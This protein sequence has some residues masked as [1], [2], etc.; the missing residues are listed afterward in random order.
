MKA[1]PLKTLCQSI[2][3]ASLILVMNYGE[4][5]GGGADIRMHVPFALRG[6]ILAQLADIFILG[7]VIFA[8]LSLLKRTRYFNWIKLVLAV[9]VPPY[10]LARMQ[11]LMPFVVEDGLIPL[12][13]AVW[14][15]LLLLLMLKFPRW[16]RHLLRVGD[17][18]GVFLAVFAVI[19]MVQLLW[20]AAWRPGAQRIAA[21]WQAASQ[22]PR[23]HPLIVWIVFDEL[24]YD[25][26]F[27][28]RAKDLALPN[29]DALRAQSTL[30]SN[31]QPIGYKTA[32]IIPSLFSGKTIDD[33]RY[34]FNNRFLVH[35]IGEPGWHALDGSGTIF[36]DAQQRGWRTAAVGWYNPY[37]TIYGDAIDA[38]Y[39]N[40]LDRIDGPMS[41]KNGFLRNTYLPLRQ[42]VREGV[43]PTRAG[44]DACDYDVG[45]RINTHLDLQQHAIQMLKGDQADFVFLHMAIPH[46]PNIWS[47]LDGAYARH[48]DSS[49]LD[50]LALVDRTLGDVLRI[51]RSSPRWNDTTLVVEGDHGWRIDLWNWLPTWTNEDDDASRGVFDPRPA[52]LVHQAGQ[53]QPQTVS[54][55]WALLNVHDVLERVLR[56]QQ[57]QY[58]Q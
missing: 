22:Q 40:N 34:R 52:L 6:I 29:F 7:F 42:L 26:V 27:E 56:G 49:Y 28:H 19:S 11:L 39:W 51:L 9:V 33:L 4:L 5:L 37:C 1:S 18:A 47:R 50:N 43:E 10:L 25:Q 41:Q 14:T 38:C 48:C 36:H 31:V 35:Y 45:Q 23:Q 17:A 15:A 12:F 13:S 58:P 46:S 44:R 54:K 8:V 2:G 24:S 57:V 3:L 32:K 20:V 53:T 21:Q 30:F 16:Y 55:P